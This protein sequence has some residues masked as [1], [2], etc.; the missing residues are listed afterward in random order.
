MEKLIIR[1][2]TTGVLLTFSMILLF[3]DK[4]TVLAIILISVSNYIINSNHKNNSSNIISKRKAYLI[5][6]LSV[7]FVVLVIIAGLLLGEKYQMIINSHPPIITRQLF[8]IFLWAFIMLILVKKY[9]KEKIHIM[10][11]PTS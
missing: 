1:Y 10:N 5:I 3:Y 7:L 8:T 6:S 4:Y 11:H 9:L 2:S